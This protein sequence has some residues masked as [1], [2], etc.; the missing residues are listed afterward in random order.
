VRNHRDNKFKSESIL[1]SHTAKLYASD[2]QANGTDLL[3]TMCGE[4][5]P[6]YFLSNPVL[7]PLHPK[8]K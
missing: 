1:D 8:T 4:K 3:Q 7:A 6:I 2:W 5:S